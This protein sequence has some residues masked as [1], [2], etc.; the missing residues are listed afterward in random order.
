M[1]SSAGGNDYDGSC[2]A[3]ARRESASPLGRKIEA[4]R[5]PL[6]AGSR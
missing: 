3:G 4:A 2:S 6:E 1:N 5:E